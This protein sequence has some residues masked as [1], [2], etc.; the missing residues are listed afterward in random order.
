MAKGFKTGGRDFV[1][2]KPGGPGRGHLSPEAKQFRKLTADE[3]IKRVNKYFFMTKTQLLRGLGSKKITTLDLYIRNS[4]VKGL[5]KGDY[6]T[7]DCMLNRIIGRPSE[8]VELT[9]PA[10]NPVI[11]TSI[12]ARMKVKDI[13]DIF[14]DIVKE[15]EEDKK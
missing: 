15:K 14:R 11:I 5:D 8:K 7:L 12:L 1:K 13:R 6:Y 10:G 9:N 3:F 2:G 4:I